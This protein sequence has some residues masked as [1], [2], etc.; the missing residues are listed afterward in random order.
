MDWSMYGW[1]GGWFGDWIGGWLDGWMDG[2]M[3]G[4]V[5]VWVAG[6]VAGW[7]ARWVAGWVD[8]WNSDVCCIPS[9]HPRA[10]GDDAPASN[11]RRGAVFFF[12]DAGTTTGPKGADGLPG[13][14]DALAKSHGALGREYEASLR[15]LQ[16]ART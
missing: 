5:A 2:W 8:G 10:P 11:P 15:M 1:M 3:D 16:G 4:W 7:V 6:W 12:V 14:L 13:R 9:R